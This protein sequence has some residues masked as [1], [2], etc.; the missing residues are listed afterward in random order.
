MRVL[1]GK[2]MEKIIAVGKTIL[3]FIEGLPLT[4]LLVGVV[5]PIMAAWIS[6]YLAERAI[7]KKENNRLYI[8]IEL[9]RKELQHNNDELSNFVSCVEEKKKL[10]KSLEFP[11]IFMKDFLISILDELQEIKDNYMHSGKF[12]WEKPVQ[13]YI[14]A[15][16]LDDL[17]KKIKE[18]ESQYY[19]DELLDGKR[20]EKLSKLIEEKEEYI[21][22]SKE[23]KDRDIYKEFSLLQM[24]L[25]KLMVGDVFGKIDREENNFILAKY[26]Y[27]K[28]KAFNEKKDKTNEDVLS[29]YKDLVIFEISSDVVKE[30]HFAQ[31]QFDLYYRAFEKAEGIQQKLYD[32][33]ENY[34]KWIV[35]KKVIQ[36]HEFSF[37]N[38]RWNENSADFV[39]I[40]DRDTYILTVELYERL[41]ETSGLDNNCEEKY[42]YCQKCCEEINV[43][44]VK[45]G[46]HEEKLRKKC[47]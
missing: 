5:V 38:K 34:Y 45:L 46:Q 14:I 2:M 4:D 16:K 27:E 26:I 25:E 3:G 35:L 40:N 13:A 33:C 15:Q 42:E 12:L 1:K 20:K 41:E 36:N 19:A 22:S 29:L 11:L 39:V 24:K 9:I 17:E 21:K 23:L 8:Q 37:E 7:K 31:E 44:M 28:V 10:E 32:L 43:V 30:E 18:L 47:K 6:F